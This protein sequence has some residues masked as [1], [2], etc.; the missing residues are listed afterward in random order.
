ML[1]LVRSP[2]FNLAANF[3]FFGDIYNLHLGERRVF[4]VDELFAQLYRNKRLKL[5]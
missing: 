3:N 4:S 5:K 1:S 2:Y